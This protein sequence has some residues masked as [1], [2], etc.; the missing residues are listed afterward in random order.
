MY[1]N[2]TLNSYTALI[3]LHEYCQIKL[4]DST[5]LSSTDTAQ[6]LPFKNPSHK[7]VNPSDYAR[8]MK[9]YIDTQQKAAGLPYTIGLAY[10]KLYSNNTRLDIEVDDLFVQDFGKTLTLSDL[11]NLGISYISNKIPNTYVCVGVKTKF[12][13]KY[14][15]TL[16]SV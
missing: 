11:S 14:L 13:G 9:T 7:Y 4:D 2:F 6:S 10:N 8:L 16:V 12:D 5:I 1:Q 3:R 15:I